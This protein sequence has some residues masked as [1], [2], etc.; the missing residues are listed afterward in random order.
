[1]LEEE[2][3]RHGLREERDLQW[4][5]THDELTE[6]GEMHGLL[7]MTTDS[8]GGDIVP[9][10]YDPVLASMVRSGLVATGKT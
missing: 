8:K 3:I 9:H 6:D 5:F 7:R 10:T 2:R 4:E 1:M